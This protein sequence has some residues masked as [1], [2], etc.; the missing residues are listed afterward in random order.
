MGVVPTRAGPASMILVRISKHSE[1][2]EFNSEKLGLSSKKLSEKSEGQ[3]EKL[4]V[5]VR[6]LFLH[7][8]LVRNL[9]VK[10][11][12]SEKFERC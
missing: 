12:L 2:F 1:Q 11:R 6:N 10:V 4:K 7:T 9:R 5:K 3:S 8:I